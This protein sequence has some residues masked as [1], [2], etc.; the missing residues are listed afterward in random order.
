[1]Q[2]GWFVMDLY[3]PAIIVLSL[4]LYLLTYK[5]LFKDIGEFFESIAHIGHSN[6]DVFNGASSGE[7]WGG[8]KFYAFLV[9]CAG[10]SWGIHVELGA[11]IRSHL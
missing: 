6:W 8:L 2:V 5:L 3:L 9:L 4:P 10:V 11:W 7:G 1:M